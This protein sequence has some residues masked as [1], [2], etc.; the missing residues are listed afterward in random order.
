MPEYDPDE[1]LAMVIEAVAENLSGDDTEVLELPVASEG[2]ATSTLW[3]SGEPMLMRSLGSLRTRVRGPP[4][5]PDGCLRFP[6]RA[7][8]TP[9]TNGFG[10]WR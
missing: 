7:P 3:P 8:R 10:E 5:S 2:A 6:Y 1:L 4:P 9:A